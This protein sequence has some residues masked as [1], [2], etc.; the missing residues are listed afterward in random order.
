MRYLSVV[1][2]YNLV[3]YFRIVLLFLLEMKWAC[4]FESLKIDSNFKQSKLQNI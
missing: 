3:D 4:M 2:T 1:I